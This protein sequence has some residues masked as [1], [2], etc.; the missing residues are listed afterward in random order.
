MANL[1]QWGTGTIMYADQRKGRL[2]WEGRKSTGDMATNLAEPTYWATAV[3]PLLGLP[4][5]SQVIAEAMNSGLSV[6][7]AP[8]GSSM[9]VD[10]GAVAEPGAPWE[11]GPVEAN[12]Q[13]RAYFFNYVPNSQLNNTYIAQSGQTQNL[14]KFAMP[15]ASIS[16]PSSTILMLEMRSSKSELPSSDPHF[17]LDLDRHRAD[18][19]RFA[20]RHNFGGHLL[21]ADNHVA[22][23]INRDVITNAGGGTA[24]T[25]GSDW[26]KPGLIWDPLGPATDG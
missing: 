18:W 20:A 22:H 16:N 10:P 17:D 3:P 2:P 1:K 25:P 26:N 19:K 12:G 6:P 5:Y 24:A 11:F 13:R 14:P 21:F 7:V 8:H 9:F 4:S 15:L 23:K